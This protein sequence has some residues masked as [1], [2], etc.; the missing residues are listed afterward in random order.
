[1][2]QQLLQGILLLPER[3]DLRTDMQ[4]FLGLQEHPTAPRKCA[5]CNAYLCL[6][7][8]LTSLPLLVRCE[9]SGAVALAPAAP[10]EPHAYSK[11]RECGCPT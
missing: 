3:R 6:E 11:Q 5:A 9:G 7:A 4:F 2:K 1:M 8:C 10:V